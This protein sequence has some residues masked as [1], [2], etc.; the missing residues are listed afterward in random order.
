MNPAGGC[1]GVAIGFSTLQ[2]GAYWYTYT[3]KS[4]LLST[5][6]PRSRRAISKHCACFTLDSSALT[7]T[8][9]CVNAVTLK[10]LWLSAMT[11][12][13]PQRLMPTPDG[14]V[15]DTHAPHRA[16]EGPVIVKDHDAVALGCQR[17]RFPLGRW[18][19]PRWGSWR[20]YPRRNDWEQ[21][22]WHW[23]WPLASPDQWMN[24][25]MN[26]WMVESINQ[27]SNKSINQGM[28]QSRDESINQ[29]SKSI[30]QSSNQAMNQ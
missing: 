11:H 19:R 5:I 20:V 24:E 26:G 9:S 2:F 21:S 1:I 28:N 23:R 29:S 12:L 6:D 8:P 25:W 13:P 15:S 3:L 22:R 18:L 17:W 27:S 16:Q 10:L 14:V 4:L 7:G 30:N